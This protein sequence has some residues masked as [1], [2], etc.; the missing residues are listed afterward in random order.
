M[1]QPSAHNCASPST[2]QGGGTPNPEGARVRGAARTRTLILTQ[3]LKGP[4]LGKGPCE[5]TSPAPTQAPCVP[6]SLC[7]R[8]A[9][10][11]QHTPLARAVSATGSPGGPH[12]GT[13]APTRNVCPSPL[14]WPREGFYPRLPRS[15][16][17]Q[18]QTQNRGQGEAGEGMAHLEL[19]LVA[20]T[21]SGAQWHARATGT[22]T[23]NT[24]KCC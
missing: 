12:R 7:S 8:K 5:P 23:P 1:A 14:V 11:G 4:S 6:Q 18:R 16:V 15:A 19:P 22:T 21:T 24:A 20:E 9:G 3:C 17:C 10:Q 13:P 2:S